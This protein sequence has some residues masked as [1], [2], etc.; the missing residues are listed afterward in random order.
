MEQKY[1]ININTSVLA[2]QSTDFLVLS[3][4]GFQFS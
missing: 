2:V 3:L 1:N 4:V